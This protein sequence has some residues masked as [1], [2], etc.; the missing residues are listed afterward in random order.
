MARTSKSPYALLGI[1][2]MAPRSGYGIKKL[3]DVSTRHFWRE[4]YGQ[5]YPTLRE[6]ERSRLIES[7]HVPQEGRPDKTVYRITDAGRERLRAWLER[8][9]D[10]VPPRNE[11]LLKLFFGRRAPAGSSRRHVEAF[12]GEQ[13][14]RLDTY[15]GLERWLETE[16]ADH[17]GLPWWL[18]T[19]SYGRRVAE[20]LIAW[21]DETL[22]TLAE[23]A[24]EADPVDEERP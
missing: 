1:L 5:I 22:A 17:P 7:E 8:P 14:G 10:A 4:S 12:R 18:M 13:Q 3:M 16:Y 9:P 23:L 19:L 15:A 21:C 6:L 24:P 2:A 20:G 11:L